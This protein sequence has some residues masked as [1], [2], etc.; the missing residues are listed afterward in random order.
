MIAE[1]MVQIAPQEAAAIHLNFAVV[2]LPDT[3]WTVA[4]VYLFGTAQDKKRL[5]DAQDLRAAWDVYVPC[6]TTV[7]PVLQLR[8]LVLFQLACLSLTPSALV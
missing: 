5:A 2:A 4:K 8:T 3:L 6:C 1:H 7:P